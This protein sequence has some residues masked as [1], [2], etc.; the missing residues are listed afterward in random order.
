MSK[1]KYF[2]ELYVVRMEKEDIFVDLLENVSGS[3]PNITKKIEASYPD[4]I[5]IFICTD[6]YCADE[7]VMMLMVGWPLFMKYLG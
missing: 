3:I 7:A 1:N 6:K 4:A 5:K 2:K